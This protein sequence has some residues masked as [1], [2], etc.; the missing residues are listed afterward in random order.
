MSSD[1]PSASQPSTSSGSQDLPSSVESTASHE[2]TTH[3][4]DVT[5][6][7]P[8]SESEAIPAP[9]PTSGWDWGLVLGATA[10][11]IVAL[12][13]RFW[14]LAEFDAPVFDEVYF[15]KFAENYLDGQPLF[16]N[17]PPLGKYLIALGIM[18]WGRNELGYRVVTALFGALIPVL[19]SGTIYRL[20]YCRG[21]A[22][23]A[24]GLLLTDGLFL[25]ESRFGLMNVFLI[26]FGFAAQIFLLAGLEQ[27]AKTRLALIGRTFMFTLSGLMLGASISIKWNGLWFAFTFASL[28][29]LVWTIRLLRPQLLP[30]LGILAEI[31]HLR[32]WHYAFCFIATPILF[33]IIQWI[34]HL[35]VNPQR[36]IELQAGLAGIPDLWASVVEVNKALLG[37]QTAGNLVVTDD[38]P[39]H[40]YCSTSLRSLGDAFP[41]LKAILTNRITAAGAWSWPVLARPVGYYFNNE[42]EV[43]RDVHGL[44]NPILWWLSTTTIVVLSGLGLRRFRAV[45]AYLLLGYATNYLPWFIVSRCV[46][47]YHYMSAAA[48]SVMALAWVIYGLLISPRRFSKILGLSLVGLILASQIYFMPIWLGLPMTSDGFYARMWFRPNPIPLFCGDD[49]SC[50]KTRI[51]FP[52]IPGFNWI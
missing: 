14:R 43:W 13:L 30:R 12:A 4:L 40:P 33:Y 34:P 51:K 24:G 1:I 16:D 27:R 39:V 52:A 7:A 41:G 37:G 2:S 25:V 28:G 3:P 26:A 42:D 32:W 22:L 23:L 18:V 45:P 50:A 15:P 49:V 20:T 31:L 35:M 29:I 48:F 19:V 46:F 47:I 10:I 9:R 44:G 21:F 38:T 5:D 17:H 11:L 36:N 6:S 8:R